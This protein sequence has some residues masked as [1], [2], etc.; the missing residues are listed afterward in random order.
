MPS[1]KSEIRPKY[2]FDAIGTSW[3]IDIYQELSKSEED[4]LFSN[5]RERIDIFDKD[6][7]RF[8]SDSLVTLMSQKAG[9]YKLPEDSNELFKVYYDIY[10]IT[11]GLVT[12]LIGN[13]IS[14]AGYDAKYTLQ[15]KR[16]LSMPATWEEAIEYKYPNLKIKKPVLLDFG[17]AGKGYLVDI[18]SRLIEEKGYSK[19]CVDAGGDIY[20]RNDSELKVGLENPIDLKQVIG[21]CN[22]K[23]GQ[24]ICGSAGNRRVWNSFN[25]IINPRTLSSPVNISGV[26]VVADKAIIAD[27]LA[28]CLFFVDPSKLQDKYKFEYVI[29]YK[30]GSFVKS[31]NFNGEVFVK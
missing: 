15:Q 17:A 27:A 25:H 2:K 20:Y 26:W 11:N 13:L 18:I 5:I 7:S 31:D 10:L 3:Q 24:S 28:T 16:E 8:R 9:E 4:L 14:D 21:I 6:Y 29:V 22:L 12:P 23:S 19:Y 1:H 30:D